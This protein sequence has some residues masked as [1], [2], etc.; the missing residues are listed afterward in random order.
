VNQFE[1]KDLKDQEYL[2]VDE[3]GFEHR[4]FIK[5]SLDDIK[6]K[7]FWEANSVVR[8]NR[9]LDPK[10]IIAKTQTHKFPEGVT[11]RTH[12]IRN[13]VTSAYFHGQVHQRSY[14]SGTNRVTYG[15]VDSKLIVT[16]PMKSVH[17]GRDYSYSFNGNMPNDMTFTEM[18]Q[19]LEYINSE[20]KEMYGN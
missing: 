15:V 4:G 6:K 9:N 7:I 14:G 2:G 12:S 8:R 18:G 13:K 3:N 11:V 5:N 1:M 17:N 10:Q 19:I 20:L 16:L